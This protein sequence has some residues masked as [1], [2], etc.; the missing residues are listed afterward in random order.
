MYTRLISNF[1]FPLQERLKRHTT[2]AVR[3]RME[4][5]QWWDKARL[6]R[7]Q[8]ERLRVLLKEAALHVPYYRELFARIGFDPEQVT[9]LAD[10]ARLPLLTKTE[11]RANLEQLKAGNAQGLARFNTGGSSGEPL[12]FFIGNERVSH[13]VAAKWRATRWW[14]VDIGDPE[15]VMWGSPIELGSQ[16]RIRMLRDMLMRTKLLPAFEMSPEKLDRFIAE[17]RAARPKM[18]FGYPSALAHVAAHAEAKGI[19]MDDLGT[20]VAFVTSEKLYDHQCEKIMKIFGCR[21][22]NGYG[23][24]DAGFIAHECP[25][26]GMHITA[27]DIIVEIVDSAGKVLP[28]GQPGEIV[29]THLATRDFPFIRYRTGDV[30]ILDEK[31]CPCGRGLPLLKEIQG[32]ATDFLVAQNGTVMHGLA[33][34]YILRDLPGVAQFKII[35]ESLDRTRIQIATT[36]AFNESAISAIVAGVQQRLGQGVAVEIE[37]VAEIQKEKSGKFRYVVS[38]VESAPTIGENA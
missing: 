3:K 38:H 5:T 29:V 14:G 33:L 4:E 8:I 20:K 37:R 10:L 21:V 9:S 27:E 32:R 30:G 34:V 24:R 15:I 6:D 2:V 25:S 28:P 19:R 35:Q 13:D 17:I 36:A 7:L 31:A 12:I 26:G 22:A 16:D 11:I 1:A 23:G 18:L